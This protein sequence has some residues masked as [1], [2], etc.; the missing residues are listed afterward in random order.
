[1]G[2]ESRVWDVPNGSTFADQVVSW[3]TSCGWPSYACTAPNASPHT[4]KLNAGQTYKLYIVQ[5]EPTEIEK[6]TLSLTDTASSASSASSCGDGVCG[7]ETCAS[8][9]ADCGTCPA[10]PS[11]SCG[12]PNPVPTKTFNVAAGGSLDWSAINTALSNGHVKVSFVP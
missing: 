8:C 10:P 9:S 1:S 2:D 4:Y 5:R 6:I 3:R 11:S 7:G 12:G